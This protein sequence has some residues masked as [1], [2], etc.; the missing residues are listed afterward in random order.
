MKKYKVTFTETQFWEYS[1]EVEASTEREA[2]EKAEDK[3]FNGEQSDDNSVTDSE[4]TGYS[5]EEIKP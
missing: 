2:W 4:N 5:V 3:Y 1:Y